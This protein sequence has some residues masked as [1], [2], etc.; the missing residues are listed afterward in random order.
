MVVQFEASG[1]PPS[2][3]QRTHRCVSVN[4]APVHE[5][6]AAVSVSPTTAVPEMVG[7]ELFTG[8]A[9]ERASA[10]VVSIAAAAARQATATPVP[11]KARPFLP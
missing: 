7:G 2:A 1:S 9:A 6:S 11:A 10:P 3:P 4:G 5:P 8:A